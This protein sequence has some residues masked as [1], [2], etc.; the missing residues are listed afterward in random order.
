MIEETERDR[1]FELVVV[2]MQRFQEGSPEKNRIRN[3]RDWCNRHGALRNDFPPGAEP[4][5]TAWNQLVVECR[6]MAQ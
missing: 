3:I 5:K 4:E 6:R 1:E 2:S